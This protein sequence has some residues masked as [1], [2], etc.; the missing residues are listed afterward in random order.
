MKEGV[1]HGRS[2]ELNFGIAGGFISAIIMFLLNLG[3]Q[4]GG[5]FPETLS[6]A[7]DIYGFFGYDLTWFGLILGT[8]YAFIDGFIIFWV[9]ALIYNKLR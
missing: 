6:F 4:I 9:F 1:N 8:I 3:Y 2:D 7:Q 5:L